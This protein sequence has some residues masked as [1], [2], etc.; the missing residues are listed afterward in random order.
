MGLS[1]QGRD[2]LFGRMVGSRAQR[3]VS[4]HEPPRNADIRTH[5]CTSIAVIVSYLQGIVD[6][7]FS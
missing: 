7:W 2:A 3:G 5:A 1:G 4:N 6:V